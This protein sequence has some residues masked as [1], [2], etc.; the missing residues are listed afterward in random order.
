M[1]LYVDERTFHDCSVL[2]AQDCHQTKDFFSHCRCWGSPSAWANVAP[3]CPSSAWALIVL[4]VSTLI[5]RSH[6]PLLALSGT[7]RLVVQE[8]DEQ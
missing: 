5:P 7:S 8:G 4:R 6:R 2:S 1:F 3:C